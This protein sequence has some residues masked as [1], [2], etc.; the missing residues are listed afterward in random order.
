MIERASKKKIKQTWLLV[1][2]VYVT[3]LLLILLTVFYSD[4]RHTKLSTSR[5]ESFIKNDKMNNIKREVENRIDEINYDLNN[6]Q[7]SQN[8]IIRKKILALEGLL[9]SKNIV[10]INEI[11]T[12][13][14]RLISVDKNYLYFI[15]NTEGILLKSGT[16]NSIDGTNIIDLKD[17]NGVYFA[18]EMLKSINS[19]NGRYITY[20]WPKVINGEPLKKTSFCK[21]IHELDIIIG[22]GVY[23]VDLMKDLHETVYSRLK[24]YYKDKK[25]YIFVNSF[26]GKSLVHANSNLI[27]SNI[28][29]M[30]DHNGE[31]IVNNM[32]EIIS[33]SGKGF[34]SYPH[35]EKDSGIVSEKISYINSLGNDWKAYIGMGFHTKDFIFKI[36]EYKDFFKKEHLNE[37]ILSIIIFLLLFVAM[38]ILTKRGVNLQ[39]QYIK[40]KDLVYEDLFKLSSEGILIVSDIGKVLYQN[41]LSLKILGSDIQD[42]IGPTGH[43]KFKKAT[44]NILIVTNLKNRTY[45]LESRTEEIIYHSID[46]YLYFM[47][48]I[49][50]EYLKT[51]ELTKMALF[52]ELTA[53]PNRRQLLNDFED[54]FSDD[55][56]VK[57]IVFGIIDLD[58]F[59]DVNDTHGHDIGDNVLKTMASSFVARLRSRDHIYRYGGEE[60]VVILRNINIEHAVEILEEINMTLKVST[61][62]RFGFPV[63]YSAG[64]VFVS[65]ESCDSTS[66]ETIFKE[67]DKLL[68]MAKEAGRNRIMFKPPS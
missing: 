20:L 51:N 18:K 56:K 23:E 11:V 17:K 50:E 36:D 43:I 28:S 62:A 14:E 41:K 29:N 3:G 9:I 49:T 58:H 6:L 32:M 38:Y 15:L 19:I 21:Y 31:F 13:F 46:S 47:R 8:I 42:N 4:L 2:V 16:E 12:E 34:I 66:F 24:Y 68:Y 39:L 25:E 52:D 22:T 55:S 65:K 10:G 64:T 37:L 67:T 30:K 53:L 44:E 60:F 45:Y 7:S 61:M 40:Q 5:F 48:D 26:D 63:T 54:I 59:K 1:V 33:N 57:S 35:L 27:N